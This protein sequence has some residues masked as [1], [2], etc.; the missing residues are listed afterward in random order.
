MMTRIFKTCGVLLLGAALQGCVG[1]GGQ[2]PDLQRDRI[3]GQPLSSTVERPPPFSRRI[4]QSGGGGIGGG[5]AGFLI[6]KAVTATL[7]ADDRA[8]SKI[9]EVPTPQGVDPGAIIE[10]TIADYLIAEFGAR[11]NLRP[12]YAGSL[13]ETGANERAAGV[14]NLARRRGLS[15]VVIDVVALEYYADSSGRNLGL[16][17]EAFR[18]VIRA[19]M[20]LVDIATGEVLAFGSC[21]GTHD[22]LTKIEAA[23]EDGPRLTTLLAQK[24]AADCAGQLIDTALK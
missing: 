20:N 10:N 4:A 11:P 18:I 9:G 2:A 1:A 24:A 7:N 16:L 14:A 22:N 5:I 12:F 19:E 21:T 3:A 8:R 17:D 15:G 23:I 6:G 13:R